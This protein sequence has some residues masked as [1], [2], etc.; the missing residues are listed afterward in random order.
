MNMNKKNNPRIE[1]TS[2]FQKQHKASSRNVKFAFIEALALFLVD[3]QHLTLR[4]HT[5]KG[6]LSGYRSIDVTSDVRAIFKLRITG[7]TTIITFHMI[8][9]HV[10]LY[11]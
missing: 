6:T 7:Q 1:F 10:E 5:L 4:N 9:T 8:G 11:G 3:P 2:L